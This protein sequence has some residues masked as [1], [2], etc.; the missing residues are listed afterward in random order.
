MGEA[1]EAPL[2]AVQPATR[3]V[4]Y[5]HVQYTAVLG[6]HCPTTAAG[7]VGGWREAGSPH[8]RATP[9][10]GGRRRNAAQTER[11]GGSARAPAP[12][13]ALGLQRPAGWPA[14]WAVVKSGQL[15]C[16]GGDG[17]GAARAGRNPPPPRGRGCVL[18]G[19]SPRAAP[20]PPPPGASPHCRRPPR[21]PSVDGVIVHRYNCTRRPRHAP[22][23]TR[24][25]PPATVRS[26]QYSGGRAGRGA[27]WRPP[28]GARL[29]R[30]APSVGATAAAAAATRCRRCR[31]RRRRPPRRAPRG[32]TSPGRQPPRRGGRS[33]P[34]PRVRVCSSSR[35]G[36]PDPQVAPRTA[37]GRLPSPPALHRRRTR[38][39]G[40]LSLGRGVPLQPPPPRVDRFWGG[41]RWGG[42]G[43]AAP[44]AAA[45][46][47]RRGGTR[48]RGA[49]AAAVPVRVRRLGS[50]Q[51]V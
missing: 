50:A 28:F 42:R 43:G 49:R 16:P 15:F 21:G 51:W 14:D 24:P 9:P 44:A 19:P 29:R 38:V 32:V 5:I 36:L 37:S 41:G 10:S 26:V 47:L 39:R 46:S 40:A 45:A 31:R 17:P 34:A 3:Y 33:A 2:C 7:G 25:P 1:R 12:P 11:L 8:R 22:F 35:R 13:N 6:R 48:R 18:A 4:Q 23:W 20:R 27:P 30:Q